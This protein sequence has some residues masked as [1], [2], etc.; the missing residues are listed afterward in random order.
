MYVM[1]AVPGK[2]GFY[3]AFGIISLA[4]LGDAQCAESSNKFKTI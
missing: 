2:K 4:S 3:L 1:Q